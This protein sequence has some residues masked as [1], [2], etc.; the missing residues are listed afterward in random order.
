[1][2]SINKPITL[3]DIK[4]LAEMADELMTI[5]NNAKLDLNQNIADDDEDGYRQNCIDIADE[6]ENV[7]LSV[8][9]WK[10]DVENNLE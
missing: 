9:D 10:N 3:G 1:M 8:G 5:A 7:W 6:V 2:L 4:R